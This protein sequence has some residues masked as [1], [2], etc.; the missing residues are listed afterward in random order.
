MR[1]NFKENFYYFLRKKIREGK[2]TS[3]RE[4]AKKLYTKNAY[5]DINMWSLINKAKS[6]SFEHLDLICELLEVTPNDL[7][8]KRK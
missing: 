5:P 3:K 1:D 6:I 7:L 8:L 4:F 2:F